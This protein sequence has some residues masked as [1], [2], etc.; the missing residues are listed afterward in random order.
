M[1]SLCSEPRLGASQSAVEQ[2]TRGS[3]RYGTTMCGWV[4][5][6]YVLEPECNAIA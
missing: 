3:Q 4:R 5:M 1:I 6:R 2:G